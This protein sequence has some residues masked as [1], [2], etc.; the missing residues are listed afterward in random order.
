VF[1]YAAVADAK[2]K[3]RRPKKAPRVPDELADVTDVSLTDEADGATEAAIARRPTSGRLGRFGPLVAAVMASL[4]LSR[5]EDLDLLP[6]TRTVRARTA[7]GRF[8][9]VG[10]APT[11]KP[12]AA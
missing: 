11:P 9:A 10:P 6:P 1:N 4:A 8:E 12:R 5:D 7:A 2:A 3:A